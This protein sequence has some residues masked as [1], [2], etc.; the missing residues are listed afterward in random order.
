MRGIIVAQSGL[1]IYCIADISVNNLTFGKGGIENEEGE[2]FTININDIS[3]VVSQAEI[4][5][6]KPSRKNNLIHEKTIE[7]VMKDYNV[8]PFR[9][10]IV[11]NNREDVQKLLNEK[12][13]YFKK[14]LKKVKNKFEMGVKVTYSNIKE[15]LSSIGDSHP[16]IVQLKKEKRNVTGNQSII[17]EVGKIIEQ[18][19]NDISLKY[20]DS[21]Y[22][23]LSDFA[24]ES[25]INENLSAEMILNA[26]FLIDM[27]KEQD[28]DSLVY[29]LDEEFKGKLNFKC[30]G[31]FPPFSFVKV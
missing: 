19:L 7:M 11:A 24:S 29:R 14:L 17:I 21:I 2:I 30:A 8:L 31:P 22:K 23:S 15:A 10:G 13:N 9:F 26:S 16:V 3:A 28:F 5:Q 1:Y 20:K 27:D 4:K 25:I 6:Y 12:Y 18:E